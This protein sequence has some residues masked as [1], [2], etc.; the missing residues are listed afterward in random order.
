[1][2]VKQYFEE[3]NKLNELL[4]HEELYWKQRAKAHWLT[5]GDTNSKFFHAAASKRKKMNHI[6]HL[7]N[8]EG[9]IQSLCPPQH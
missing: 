1:M 4:Y 3:K 8:N 6:H 9:D 2:G 7:I 5:E